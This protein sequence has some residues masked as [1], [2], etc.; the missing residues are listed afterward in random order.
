MKWLIAL[1]R[2]SAAIAVLAARVAFADSVALKMDAGAFLVP[3]VINDRITL[4][5]L[6]DSGSSDVSI[7]ADVFRTLIRTGTISQDD[8]LGKV[9][10]ILADGSHQS[11]QLF[12]IRSL[13]VGN[14]ELRNVTGSVAPV[15]G[16]LLL[17]QTFLSQL[18]TWSIDN[19][20]HVLLLNESVGPA[21]VSSERAPEVP[22][23]HPT[24]VTAVVPATPPNPQMQ[25]IVQDTKSA[26]PVQV[27]DANDPDY[28]CRAAETLC[29]QGMQMCGE[30]RQDF[31]RT[32]R[33]CPG[34]TDVVTS[35]EPN[36]DNDPDYSCRAAQ[37]LCR[38]G[39]SMCGV[40]RQEFIRA[41]RVCPGVTP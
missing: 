7:P 30:Y 18:R 25:P 24:A 26:V 9:T 21:V 19:Q 20:R 40:Y 37:N 4:D 32:G 5:F 27:N 17:G 11:A 33:D 3:V 6:L 12:R 10:H 29:R 23:S 15:E 16:D 2:V 31:L 35:A 22:A 38:S 13:K 1:T 41:G 36:N 34:V 39:M 8:L 28:S 14:L